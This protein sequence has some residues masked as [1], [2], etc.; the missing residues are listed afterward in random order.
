[1]IGTGKRKEIAKWIL[2]VD[3]SLVDLIDQLKEAE[4]SDWWDEI[5]DKR[6][7]KIQ[8]GYESVKSGNTIPH[9]EIVKKYGL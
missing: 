2:S 9:S 7:R 1:M 5:S 8:E 4:N 3:E 6:K